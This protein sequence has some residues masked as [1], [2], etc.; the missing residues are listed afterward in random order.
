MR[1]CSLGWGWGIGTNRNKYGRDLIY[2]APIDENPNL[3]IP[4]PECC[5]KEEIARHKAVRQEWNKN[6][7]TQI[8]QTRQTSCQNSAE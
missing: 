4:D 3:F 7:N 2:G 8:N 1:G 5:T 6:H